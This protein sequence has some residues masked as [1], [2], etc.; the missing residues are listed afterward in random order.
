MTKSPYF[1]FN[2]AGVPRRPRQPVVGLAVEGVAR[3]VVELWTRTAARSPDS[4][5]ECVEATLDGLVVLAVELRQLLA[6]EVLQ[7]GDGLNR[8][9]CSPARTASPW[10]WIWLVSGGPGCA[11][12]PGASRLRA[13]AGGQEQNDCDH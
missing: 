9:T 10:I 4:G 13:A 3:D 11:L 2:S 1:S 8:P 12:V 6:P 5:V 7:V